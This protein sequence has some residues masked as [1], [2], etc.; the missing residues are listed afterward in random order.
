[1]APQA[2]WMLDGAY[3]WIID[4]VLF[5]ESLAAGYDELAA[6]SDLRPLAAAKVNPGHFNR[7]K[8]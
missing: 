6:L 7:L 1:M 2:V 3:N 8:H 5:F 4:Y